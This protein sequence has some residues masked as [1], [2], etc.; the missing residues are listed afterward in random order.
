MIIIERIF[1]Y[2]IISRVQRGNALN[3]PRKHLTL[4]ISELPYGV[5]VAAAA[6]NGERITTAAA[7]PPRFDVQHEQARPMLAMPAAQHT[8][9]NKAIR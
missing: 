4:L 9:L 2:K 7:G 1:C 8:T 6:G 5:C 3:L